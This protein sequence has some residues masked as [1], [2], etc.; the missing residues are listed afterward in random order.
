MTLLND[1]ASAS[2]EFRVQPPFEE[3]GST[4]RLSLVLADL[5][6]YYPLER[7]FDFTVTVLAREIDVKELSKNNTVGV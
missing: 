7:E 5:N 6:L 4:Y 2:I 3:A 1:T